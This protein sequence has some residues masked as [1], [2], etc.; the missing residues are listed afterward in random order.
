MP[1]LAILFG[2]SMFGIGFYQ[3]RKAKAIKSWPSVKGVVTGSKIVPGRDKDAEGNVIDQASITYMY[4]VSG[5]P[6]HGNRVKM[7]DPGN[8]RK[9]IARYSKDRRVLVYYDPANPA[10]AVLERGSSNLWVWPL[11]GVISILLGLFKL[12]GS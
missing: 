3:S 9:L 7:G 10:S 4:A 8:A 11:I 5:S 12:V 2:L 1:V 6:F